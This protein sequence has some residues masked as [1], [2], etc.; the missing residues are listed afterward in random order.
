M[1]A[2][3]ILSVLKDLESRGLLTEEVLVTVRT[4]NDEVPMAVW[5]DEMMYVEFN[6]QKEVQFI[7][8]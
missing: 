3:D 6:H 4:R 8:D 1:R 5:V 2:K 7:T